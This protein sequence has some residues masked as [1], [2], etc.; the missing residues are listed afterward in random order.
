MILPYFVYC[1]ISEVGRVFISH[2]SNKYKTIDSEFQKHVANSKKQ[3]RR[4]PAIENAII[5]YGANK[6]ICMLMRYCA[7]LY[8]AKYWENRYIHGMKTLLPHGYNMVTTDN[9]GHNIESALTPFCVYFIISPIGKIYVGYTSWSA[10]E[11]YEKHVA[12]S[13]KLERCSA[14]VENAIIKY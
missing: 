4:S 13:K 10:E 1:I 14:A 6:M 11:R 9:M 5:M 8:E 7:S 2:S 12:N 3:E